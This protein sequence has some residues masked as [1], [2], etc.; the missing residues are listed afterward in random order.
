LNLDSCV[1]EL[2][3]IFKRKPTKDLIVHLRQLLFV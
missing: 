2:K 3:I 1:V